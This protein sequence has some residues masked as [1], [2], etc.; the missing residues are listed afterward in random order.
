MN[1]EPV[2]TTAAVAAVITALVAL[3]KSFGVPISDDMAI[4]LVG[5]VGA[6][7]PMVAAFVA[8]GKVTPV[9]S[10]RHQL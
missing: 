3:L 10:A 8:R 6:A 7:G 1:R 5:V 2:L 9:P 4:A